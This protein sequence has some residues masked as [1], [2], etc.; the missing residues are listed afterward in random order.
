MEINMSISNKNSGYFNRIYT[1]VILTLEWLII[2]FSYQNNDFD[3]Y[4]LMYNTVNNLGIHTYTGLEI[5]QRFL[6]KLGGDFGLTYYQF[7]GFYTLV[8][9]VILWAGLRKIT[10]N[11]GLTLT[12]YFIFPFIYDVTQ[13]R[14]FFALCLMVF[15]FHFL[16]NDGFKRSILP[17][18]S[19]ILLAGLIHSISFFYIIFLLTKIKKIRS[20]YWITILLALIAAITF[21]LFN[22]LSY[23]LI[24]NKL[25]TYSN[26]DATPFSYKILYA[27]IFLINILILYFVYQLSLNGKDLKLQNNLLTIYKASILLIICYPVVSIDEVFFRIFRDFLIL[28]YAAVTLILSEKSYKLTLE[29]I[30]VFCFT[31]FFALVNSY[32]W[33][34]ADGKYNSLVLPIFKY[35][36]IFGR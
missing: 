30:S 28:T 11:V 6:Y 14:N 2:G 20:I 8:A 22:S 10:N 7:V 26:V 25:A 16:L 19:I 1:L 27:I 33:L 18:C 24:V 15:A 4:Q 31:V 13:V 3:T 23:A 17:Y 35:N 21:K 12:I 5:G 36:F 29:K 34:F 9:I 32:V